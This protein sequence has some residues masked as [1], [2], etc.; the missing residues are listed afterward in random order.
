L[1]KEVPVHFVALRDVL[2]GAEV[3]VSTPLVTAAPSMAEQLGLP[4]F[5]LENTPV[6]A[7]PEKFPCWGVE[8]GTSGLVNILKTGSR[9]RFWN[10]SVLGIV[11]REREF[12]RLNPITDLYRYIFESGHLL[13]TIDP[14]MDSTALNVNQNTTG[15]IYFDPPDADH[16]DLEKFLESGNPPVYVNLSWIRD[17]SPFLT[18]LCHVFVQAGL[19]VVMRADQSEPLS[20]DLPKE[21]IRIEETHLSGLFSRVAAVIHHGDPETTAFAVRAGIPHVTAPWLEA[22]SY[23]AEK[24]YAR[25]IGAAPI[26]DPGVEELLKSTQTVLRDASLAERARALADQIRGRDGT[27]DAADLIERK[28]TEALRHGVRT[29]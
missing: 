19:R 27:A 28:T 29:L 5:C 10:S 22:H 25:G 4:Y 6:Y 3:L 17:K 14:E 26:R 15:F 2:R 1:R 24:V 20:S 11:N 9:R 23:W 12:S 16:A 13:F 21:C 18:K 8:H 7:D